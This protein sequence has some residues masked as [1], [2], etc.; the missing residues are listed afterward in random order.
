LGKEFKELSEQ[1]TKEIIEKYETL[2]N[3]IKKNGMGAR[4][5]YN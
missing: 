4:N 2:Q 3:W 1:K 5:G